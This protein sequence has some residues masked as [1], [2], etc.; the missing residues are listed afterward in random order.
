[1]SATSDK[2]KGA[3]NATVGAAKQGL[4]KAVG[5]PKVEAEGAAQKATGKVQGAVGNAKATLKRAIDKA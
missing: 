1:M 3:A 4:G 5:N 2:I